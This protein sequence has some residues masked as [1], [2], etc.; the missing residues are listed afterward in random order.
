MVFA[1]LFFRIEDDNIVTWQTKKSET[2]RRKF[3]FE[4]EDLLV[5]EKEGQ[6]FWFQRE[7]NDD[8]QNTGRPVYSIHLYSGH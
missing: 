2:D 1:N 6:R 8:S 7:P 3:W 4:E 5:L